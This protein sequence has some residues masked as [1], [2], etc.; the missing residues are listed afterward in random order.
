MSKPTLVVA[1]VLTCLASTAS[2]GRRA[3][4]T[5]QQRRDLAAMYVSRHRQEVDTL[6]SARASSKADKARQR[7]ELATKLIAANTAKKN[8]SKARPQTR[9]DAALAAEIRVLQL[10]GRAAVELGRDAR[11][12]GESIRTALGKLR[13]WFGG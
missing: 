7:Q 5:R 3:Q 6:A 4:L 9:Q 11:P 10:Q 12:I 2:A 8:A 13:R 1:L